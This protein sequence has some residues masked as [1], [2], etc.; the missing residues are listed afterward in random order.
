MSKQDFPPT[1]IAQTLA[2]SAAEAKKQSEKQPKQKAK[3]ILEFCQKG[4]DLML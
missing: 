3:Y 1:V 4:V 2:S